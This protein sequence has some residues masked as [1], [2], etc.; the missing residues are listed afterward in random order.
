MGF[1][2]RYYSQNNQ[3]MSLETFTILINT[4]KKL[5]D[6]NNAFDKSLEKVLGTDSTV[7]TN[8]NNGTIEYIEKH[9]IEHFYD[10][11]WIEYYIWECLIPDNNHVITINNIEYKANIKIIYQIITKQI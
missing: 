4:I 10:N 11:E 7:M 1:I 8:I 6:S 5:V 9:L 3:F 2:M